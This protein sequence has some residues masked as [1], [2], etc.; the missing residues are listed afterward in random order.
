MPTLRTVFFP[1]RNPWRILWLCGEDKELSGKLETSVPQRHCPWLGTEYQGDEMI[2]AWSSWYGQ[3]ESCWGGLNRRVMWHVSM[4]GVSLGAAS[5][6]AACPRGSGH[7]VGPDVAW[8]SQF[9]LYWLLDL[10]YFFAHGS[11][12]ASCDC[13]EHLTAS[14]WHC[15]TCLPPP[16]KD[17][18]PTGCS[19]VFPL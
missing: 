15:L 11:I 6:F 12:S 7:S 3:E 18:W 17:L 16:L 1:P 14:V 19:S 9:Y 10:P 4:C 8:G 2:V 5:V 13:S